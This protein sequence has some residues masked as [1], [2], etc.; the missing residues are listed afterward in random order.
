[1]SK[2]ED[3]IKKDEQGESCHMQEKCTEVGEIPLHEAV[4]I[5]ENMKTWDG[6]A[7]LKKNIE[8]IKE[9]FQDFGTKNGRQEKEVT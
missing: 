7:H 3:A 2:N 6:A 9:Q 1:M 4:K 5:H 8:E